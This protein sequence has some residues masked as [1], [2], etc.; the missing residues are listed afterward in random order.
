LNYV[1]NGSGNP[2]WTDPNINFNFVVNNSTG[3]VNGGFS[4]ASQYCTFHMLDSA[5]VANNSQSAFMGQVSGT[6][7]FPYGANGNTTN[8][9]SGQTQSCCIPYAVSVTAQPSSTTLVLNYVFPANAAQQYWCSSENSANGTKIQGGSFNSLATIVGLNGSVTVWNDPTY[10]YFFTATAG[11]P[12]TIGM[13]LFPNNTNTGAISCSF[14][15]K[16]IPQY[17]QNFNG[18]WSSVWQDNPNACC[19]PSGITFAYNSNTAS[20]LTASYSFTATELSNSFCSIAGITTNPM[21]QLVQNPQ[22][23]DFGGYQWNDASLPFAYTYDP[24][25]TM[26]WGAYNFLQTS[27]PVTCHFALA[28]SATISSASTYVNSVVGTW[29]QASNFTYS[30]GS[31]SPITTSQCCIPNT[32][33]ITN[34][35]NYVLSVSY[36]FNSDATTDSWCSLNSIKG[37]SS[38]S[39][40]EISAFQPNSTTWSDIKNTFSVQVNTSST[41]QGLYVSYNSHSTNGKCSFYVQT[42]AAYGGKLAVISSLLFV[43]LS[44]LLL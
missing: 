4:G 14:N 34:V 3:M 28:P 12:K 41:T 25:T 39:S 38:S 7:G 43:V 18:T 33:T 37:G 13:I 19:I 6:W 11:G 21:T 20:T 26:I 35:S 16:P 10:G 23:G 32:F 36:N 30:S 15:V 31:T 8:G 1:D 42:T 40:L 24:N 44:F 5:A 22:Y 17:S 2:T 27:I 29:G 9:G